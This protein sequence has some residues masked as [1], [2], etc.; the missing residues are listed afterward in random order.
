MEMKLEELL[1]Y[2]VKKELEMEDILI[3]DDEYAITL[4]QAQGGM[5]IPR[6][7]VAVDTKNKI[8][9]GKVD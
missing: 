9:L 3:V 7:A 1:K 4:R 8:A 2:V 5:P 6:G